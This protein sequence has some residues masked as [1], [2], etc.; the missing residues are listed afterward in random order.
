MTGVRI[1]PHLSP[2][3]LFHVERAKGVLVSCMA[4]CVAVYLSPC[5]VYYQSSTPEEQTRTVRIRSR[6]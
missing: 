6:T 1:L 4:A 5:L 3:S 2:L